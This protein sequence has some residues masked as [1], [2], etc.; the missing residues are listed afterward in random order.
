MIARENGHDDV[1]AVL[2]SCCLTADTVTEVGRYLRV[3]LGVQTAAD[4]SELV[5][6]FIDELRKKIILVTPCRMIWRL[7]V[8]KG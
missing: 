2:E 4:L 8:C 5:E 1:V 7:Y 3:T 6:E